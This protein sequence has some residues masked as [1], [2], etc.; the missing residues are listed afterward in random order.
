MIAKD[1]ETTSIKV[2]NVVKRWTKKLKSSDAQQ[3]TRAETKPT[4]KLRFSKERYGIESERW[5]R[6]DL[7][8]DANW[9]EE[10]RSGKT[11]EV[12]RVAFAVEFLD[13]NLGELV[14]TIDHALH[15]ISGQK[16]VPT[17][18]AWGHELM[19]QLRSRSYISKYVII[20]KY[21][22]GSYRLQI[23]DDA[24]EPPFLS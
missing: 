18:L 10:V 22:D 7:F 20:E 13:Q 12:T 19:R 5:F 24:P 2:D 11:Y 3:P 23:A 14:L 9:V 4:G 8:G 1:A 16:N 21:E 15:R 6:N 17:V